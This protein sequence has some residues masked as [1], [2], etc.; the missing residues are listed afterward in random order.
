ALG[1]ASDLGGALGAA[2]GRDVRYV[3]GDADSIAASAAD[4]TVVVT[5]V[6]TSATRVA[7]ANSFSSSRTYDETRGNYVYRVTETERSFTGWGPFWTFSFQ[8]ELAEISGHRV[9]RRLVRY[10]GASS[11]KPDAYGAAITDVANKV[12]ATI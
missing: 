6:I 10:A 9:A 11:D 3:I 5:L 8:I 12:V 4:G 7:P 2:A 1:V